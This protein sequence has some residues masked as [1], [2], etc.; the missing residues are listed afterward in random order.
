M[1]TG[2]LRGICREI[3]R[4]GRQHFG[5]MMGIVSHIHDNRYEILAVD[6]EIAT[7]HAG[8]IFNL[9]AVYCREVVEKKQTIAITEID[10]QAGMC[11]HP[12]YKYVPC[13]VYISSPIMVNGEVWGTLNYTSMDVRLNPFSS[14]D[15]EYNETQAAR[16][17]SA[18]R[19]CVQ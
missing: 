16:I 10:G 2:G 14:E 18:I 4:D 19:A 6:S 13:E 11:L 3:L 5:L 15:I 1:D 9:Q 12:L 7:P 8:D 17:A